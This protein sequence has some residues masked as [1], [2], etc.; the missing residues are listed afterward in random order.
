MGRA[1]STCFKS[2]SAR[3]SSLEIVW[4]P[5]AAKA[6]CIGLGVSIKGLD[7]LTNM[8]SMVIDFDGLA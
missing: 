4:F 1:M 2:K 8:S 6:V 5:S 7:H 3:D